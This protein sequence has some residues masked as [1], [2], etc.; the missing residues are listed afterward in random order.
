MD[1]MLRNRILLPILSIGFVGILWGCAPSTQPVADKSVDARVTKLEREL[2]TVQDAST[3]L[4]A[5]IKQEQNRVKDVEKER[6]DLKAQLKSRSGERDA[7]Q[8]QYDGFRKSMKELI[9]QADAAAATLNFK[10]T[11]EVSAALTPQ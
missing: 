11:G 2:K 10:P 5:Q 8:A 1:A 7:V 3:A 4:A 9:G 6:D